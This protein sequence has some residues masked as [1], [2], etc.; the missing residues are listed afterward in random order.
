MK[1]V[2]R[3]ISRVKKYLA[4]HPAVASA[5][6]H[7]ALAAVSSFVLTI[8]PVVSA[9]G[10]GS[11]DIATVKALV[12]SAATGAVAAGARAVGIWIAARGETEIPTEPT[13]DEIPED[14]EE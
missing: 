4:D 6:R 2:K 9:V 14:T 5:L 10:A 12:L 3:A 7:F 13:V 1:I 11:Y 8:V